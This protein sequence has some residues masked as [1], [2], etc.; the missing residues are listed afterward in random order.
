MTDEARHSEPIV[1]ISD[2]KRLFGGWDYLYRDK[3]GATVVDDS[4]DFIES[5]EAVAALEDAF[6]KY[7]T[8]YR[9][10]DDMHEV[11]DVSDLVFAIHVSDEVAKAMDLPDS[12]KQRGIFSVHRAQET[13]EGE[14]LWRDIKGGRKVM[15]SIVGTGVRR[16]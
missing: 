14:S 3:D 16:A 10:G 2:E 4:G 12:Y 13:E 1:K 6:A 8:E 9:T 11:G 5:P 7:A 15:K